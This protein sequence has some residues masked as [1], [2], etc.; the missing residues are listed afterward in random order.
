L[1]IDVERSEL[2]ILQGIEDLDWSKIRQIVVEV[3]DTGKRLQ[4]ISEL[5]QSRGYCVDVEQDTLLKGT[6][7]LNLYA[8]RVACG[9]NSSL[10]M[11]L[12]AIHYDSP[13]SAGALRLFLQDYLPDYM[14]PSVFI[15]LENLPLTPNGKV[16]RKALPVPEAIISASGGKVMGS[17]NPTEQ[18]LLGIWAEV[19]G[20]ETI[21]VH[22]NFF[23]LG[24]HSL[25]A[26]QVIARLQESF[27]VELPVA[28]LFE[29]PTIAELAALIVQ[30]QS[31]H[32]NNQ[33]LV[34]LL[35]EIE[36]LSDEQATKLLNRL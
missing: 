5:L 33:E 22:D 19:L 9:E 30:Q 13:L 17:C 6:S 26:I 7:V 24:G 18:V 23:D 34:S 16:D 8:T 11:P 29:S 27:D 21:S 25:S 35:E 4:K 14:I 36:G 12:P 10:S 20:I 3:E 28:S 1:K 2:D 15:F 32:L 31:D